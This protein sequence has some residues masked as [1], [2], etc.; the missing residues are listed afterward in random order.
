MSEISR[1]NVAGASYIVQMV[2]A[3]TQYKIF[4]KLARYGAA[5]MVSSM[6]RAE[7]SGGDI[8]EAIIATALTIITNMP[9]AEQDFCVENALKNTAKEGDTETVNIQ[10]FSGRIAEYLMLGARAIGVQLG[11]FSCFLSLIEDSKTAKAQE[12]NE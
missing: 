3:Q 9:E 8:R 7:Q 12:G 1:V 10:F 2:D 5:T 4:Q 11:D 6:V